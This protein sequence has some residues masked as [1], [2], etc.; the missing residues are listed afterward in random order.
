MRSYLLGRK[1]SGGKNIEVNNPT[2]QNP[3]AHHSVISLSNSPKLEIPHEKTIHNSLSLLNLHFSHN[4]KSP[5]MRQ[6]GRVLVRKN[7]IRTTPPSYIKLGMFGHWP[8]SMLSLVSW[9]HS[10]NVY[11]P[12]QQTPSHLFRPH[13]S[14][15]A[16]ASRQKFAKAPNSVQSSPKIGQTLRHTRGTLYEYLYTRQH[17][18][19][20]DRAPGRKIKSADRP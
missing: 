5:I 18:Y 3:P 7:K 4:S 16:R 6:S 9:K 17:V 20:R 8:G 13:T 1:Q 15:P 10:A 12:L 2:L 14:S 19:I 11:D